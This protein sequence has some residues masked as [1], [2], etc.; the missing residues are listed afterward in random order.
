LGF[1]DLVRISQ[2]RDGVLT[3]LCATS[4]GDDPSTVDL[5]AAFACRMGSALELLHVMPAWPDLG[6]VGIEHA[7]AARRLRARRREPLEAVERL[8]HRVRTLAG[9]VERRSMVLEGHPPRAITAAARSLAASHLVV[10][11]GAERRV[12]G[13]GPA[14]VGPTTLE[15]L[16]DARCSVLVASGREGAASLDAATWVVEIPLGFDLRRL[17]DRARFLAG[18]DGRVV[19]LHPLDI[20]AGLCEDPDDPD[21]RELLE[22]RRAH[23]TSVIRTAELDLEFEV[24]ATNPAAELLDCVTRHGAHGVVVPL[25]RGREHGLGANQLAM[26]QRARVPVLF[27]DGDEQ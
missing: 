16:R 11:P 5:A 9:P 7:S 19:G 10:G 23:F 6:S 2:P 4:L 8:N 24:A 26:L 13:A 21:L 20:P 14:P 18:R 3:V 17:V 25:R 15:V 27:V 22:A 1:A 12:D